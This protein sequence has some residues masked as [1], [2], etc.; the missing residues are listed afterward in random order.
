[1]PNF[2]VLTFLT[3][4]IPFKGY[5]KPTTLYSSILIYFAELNLLQNKFQ[6]VTAHAAL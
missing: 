4:A 3:T 2:I 6:A 5:F 1:M